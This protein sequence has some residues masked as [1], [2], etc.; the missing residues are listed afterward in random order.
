MKKHHPA[1][2]QKYIRLRHHS[3]GLRSIARHDK[4]AGLAVVRIPSSIQARSASLTLGCSRGVSRNQM[5]K[6]ITQAEPTTPNTRNAPRQ[7]NQKAQTEMRNGATAPPQR[8]N[9]HGNP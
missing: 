9:T 4:A 2:L 6:P 8:P 3:V 7:P 5:K 1:L